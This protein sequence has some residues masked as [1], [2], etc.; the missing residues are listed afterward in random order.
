MRPAWHR[1]AGWTIVAV[2]AFI[3][4]AND[5]GYIS[6]RLMPGGH[7][8]AYLLLGVI[9]AGAGTYFLGLFDRV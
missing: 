8:E 9:V 5:V 4:V 3:V 2:G 7:S 1:Y 6:K